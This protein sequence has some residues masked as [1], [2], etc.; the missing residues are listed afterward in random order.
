MPIVFNRQIESYRVDL[1]ESSNLTYDRGIRLT[2]P[3]SGGDPAHV[4]SIEFPSI[5]PADFVNI[6]TN[7]TTIQIAANRFDE[8]YHVL[9]TESPLFFSAYEFPIGGTTL[10]FAGVTSDPEATGEG[11]RDAN[12]LAGP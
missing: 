8:L 4:V 7:F 11:F 1:F 10:R 12:T 3:A 5:R 6:G 2:L 9:Q